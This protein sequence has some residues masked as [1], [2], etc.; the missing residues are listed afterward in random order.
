MDLPYRLRPTGVPTTGPSRPAPSCPDVSSHP[1][2]VSRAGCAPGSP[3]R[4]ESPGRGSGP[5]AA[6]RPAGAGR[7]GA[8]R[9]VAAVGRLPTATVRPAGTR[10]TGAVQVGALSSGHDVNSGTGWS[11]AGG[12]RRDVRAPRRSARPAVTL[13][14]RVDHGQRG[15]DDADRDDGAARRVGLG[16]ALVRPGRPGTSEWGGVSTTSPWRWRWKSADPRH[17]A[18]G[19]DA[20]ENAVLRAHVRIHAPT[21]NPR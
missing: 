11:F 10:R 8:V 20:G 18:G 2:R 7:A 17:E 5:A 16:L 13:R 3:G 12:L 21:G 6:V 4:R 19:Q 14:T 15:R 1:C 9:V